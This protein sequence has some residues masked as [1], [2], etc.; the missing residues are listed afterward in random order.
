MDIFNPEA[1]TYLTNHMV[2][3]GGRILSVEKTD[4]GSV[5]IVEALPLNDSKTMVVESAPSPG[6]FVLLYNQRVYPAALQPGNKLIVVGLFNGPSTVTFT[7]A[8]KPAPTV[9]ARCL[10]IWNTGHHAISDFPN[11][12]AGYYPLRHDTYCLNNPLAAVS[13]TTLASSTGAV[14]HGVATGDVTSDSAVL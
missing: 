1:E 13:Y 14:S 2:Q 4:E 3:I 10:H 7:G 11:L 12:P 5:M 8:R 9:R 6:S